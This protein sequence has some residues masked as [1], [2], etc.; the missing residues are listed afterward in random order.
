M[1]APGTPPRCQTKDLGLNQC[2]R[3]EGHGGDHRHVLR[4]QGVLR[5]NSHEETFRVT[6][7]SAEPLV[8]VCPFPRTACPSCEQRDHCDAC[9]VAFAEAPG[10][11]A[12][13]TPGTEGLAVELERMHGALASYGNFLAD[14]QEDGCDVP[15]AITGAVARQLR[16]AVILLEARAPSPPSPG[17]LAADFRMLALWAQECEQMICEMGGQPFAPTPRLQRALDL[18]DQLPA[19][20]GAL[21]AEPQPTDSTANAEWLRE[22]SDEYRG[23]WVALKDGELVAAHESRRALVTSLRADDRLAGVMLTMIDGYGVA[24]IHVP[25]ALVAEVADPKTPHTIR[26]IGAPPAGRP[27]TSAVTS[28]P[29]LVYSVLEAHAVDDMAAPETPDPVRTAAVG[30]LHAWDSQ[31]GRVF[32]SMGCDNPRAQFIDA[33]ADELRAALGRAGE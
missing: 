3:Q 17:A 15:I 11:Q 33:A 16:R 21:A 13:A 6:R 8:C 10:E 7:R 12:T 2:D 20:P 26:E 31:S 14:H 19:R 1:T 5:W 32:E 29:V 4:G 24:D 23:Q 22:H 9:A 30:M 27:G 18:L 25:G 28:R